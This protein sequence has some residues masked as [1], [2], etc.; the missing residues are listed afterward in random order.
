MNQNVII[1]DE[2]PEVAI[3]VAV[4]CYGGNMHSYTASSLFSLGSL[5]Q[6]NNI[7][8]GIIT[9][10]GD[11]ISAV[12]NHI[13]FTFLDFGY[14]HLMYIDSDIQF[15]P[16]SVLTLL[17]MNVEVAAAAYRLKKW[18]KVELCFSPCEE[19]TD[20]IITEVDFIG[21]GFQLVKRS[22]FEK[23]NETAA[24]IRGW[25]RIKCKDYYSNYIDTTENMITTEDVAFCRRWRQ[26]GGKVWMNRSIKLGHY[27]GISYMVE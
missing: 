5:L 6:K 22:V 25:G 19:T 9:P 17:N 16:N 27:G 21:C 3:L 8:H 20:D 24:D 14:T 2:K 4:P 1:S 7:P 10:G 26:I 11:P 15:D 23:L 13:A 12:R 18:E